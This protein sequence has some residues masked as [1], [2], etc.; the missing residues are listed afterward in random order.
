MIIYPR[1][2]LKAM[3]KTVAAHKRHRESGTGES[4]MTL[5]DERISLPSRIPKPKGVLPRAVVGGDAGCGVT[6]AHIDGY[7]K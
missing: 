2:I 5:C 3:T 4:P 6:T 1:K 7:V